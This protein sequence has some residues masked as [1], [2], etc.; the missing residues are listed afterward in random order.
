M[1]PRRRPLIPAVT[2]SRAGESVSG[3]RRVLVID[4][5]AAVRAALPRALAPLGCETATARDG[6]EALRHVRETKRGSGDRT[7]LEPFVL[8]IMDLVLPRTDG[9]RL[10]GQLW[11]E[12]P[13][14]PSILVLG[15]LQDPGAIK[16]L[17]ELGATDYIP[18]PFD[19][20]VLFHKVCV[21]L[22]E[23]TPGLFHWAPLRP[24]TM[25]SVDG[26]LATATAV[27]E[28]GLV[29][30]LRAGPA[31]RTG[32]VVSMESD[33][34][35]E[36]SGRWRRCRGRV[37]SVARVRGDSL[38]ELAFVALSEPQLHRIRRFTVTH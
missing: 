27:S 30:E 32:Q 1:L 31:L 22:G 8:V 3:P 17:L 19:L 35:D 20:D 15:S 37:V 2:S 6:D 12:F 11:E 29:V 7:R 33:F 18:K 36:P 10:L 34:L 25:V 38:V 13:T 24:R 26:Q 4:G 23:P 21:L 16:E 14:L 28:A 5:H 9:L